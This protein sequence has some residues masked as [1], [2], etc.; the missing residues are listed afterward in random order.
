M[1]T[2]QSIHRAIQILKLFSSERP[3]LGILEMS[4]LS[5]LNKGTVQGLVRTLLKEGFLRQNRETRKYQL[6]IKLYELGMASARSMAIN[7][8]SFNSAHDLAKRMEQHVRVAVFDEDA[9][10]VT[11]EAYPKSE[12]FLFRQR[13]LRALFYCSALGKAIL[14]FWNSIELDNYFERMEFTPYTP[15]TITR[16]EELRRVLEEIRELG[17]SVNRQERL[18]ERAAIGAPIFDRKKQV[19]ASICLAGNPKDILGDRLESFATEVC[20]TALEISIQMGYS[21]E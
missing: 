4:R 13:G 9:A 15:H 14:A 20:R 1:K 19:I 10:I 12:P 17:Y 16:K 5:D 21:L 18:L 6:G 2:I 7:Q 3:S 8:R 11:L